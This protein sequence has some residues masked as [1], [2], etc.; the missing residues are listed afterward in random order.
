MVRLREVIDDPASRK[1]YLAL[2]YM[3]GGE[4][5]WREDDESNQPVLSID[6]ARYIF[7]DVVSGLDYCEYMKYECVVLY[8]LIYI[9]IYYT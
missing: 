3:E 6:E 1:I 4:I 5:K 9:Y 8:I 7:R 2:E